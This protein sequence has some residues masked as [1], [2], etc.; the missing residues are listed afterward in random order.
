MPALLLYDIINFSKLIFLH[1]HAERI[2]SD[3]S[4]SR[5]QRI[6]AVS[7][8][9]WKDVKMC[10][11]EL[12]SHIQLLSVRERRPLCPIKEETLACWQKYKPL[13]NIILC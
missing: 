10:D 2:M 4:Q 5:S 3:K 13:S 1:L 12:K 9:Q 8:V 6:W 7:C 11:G